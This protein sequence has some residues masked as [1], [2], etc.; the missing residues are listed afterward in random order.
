MVLV[1]IEKGKEKGKFLQFR[2]D[3]VKSIIWRDTIKEY[4]CLEHH[5]FSLVSFQLHPQPVM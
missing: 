2:R 1:E 3:I 4:R 5:Q